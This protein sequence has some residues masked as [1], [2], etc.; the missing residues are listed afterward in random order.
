MPKTVII[1]GA[2]VAGLAAGCYAQMNGYQS[3]LFELHDIPGGLCTAWERKGYTFDGCLHYLFG[4]GPGQPF[5]RVWEE[6]GAIQD[7]VMHNHDELMRI[8]GPDGQTFTVYS[9]PDRL[10]AHM[11]ELA[12]DDHKLINDFID[13]I[14]RKRMD[15]F[16]ARYR[17][18][19]VLLLDDVQFLEGKEQ[20][21]KQ[22]KE[23][24]EKAEALAKQQQQALPQMAGRAGRTA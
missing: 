19:D 3:R 7:R 13:G 11:R 18:V 23:Q 16:K 22:L 24:G 21:L 20:L 1:I 17:G 5:Y 2:G 15:E 9:D 10:G 6:L 8:I 14:R 12:P 4:S